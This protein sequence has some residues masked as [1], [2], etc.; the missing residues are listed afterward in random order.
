MTV[1]LTGVGTHVPDETIGGADIAEQSGI[2]RDVVVE[3]MGVR[4]KHVCR[5]GE[6]HPSDMCVAAAR[7]ELANAGIDAVDPNLVQFLA[8]GTGY[9]WAATVLEW[10]D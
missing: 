2:P 9:T 7:A 1:H 3:K 5:N 8:A 10:T 6:D 4:R